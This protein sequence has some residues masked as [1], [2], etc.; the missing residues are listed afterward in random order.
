[1]LGRA[2][3]FDTDL[4]GSDVVRRGDPR[5]GV[6][7]RHPRSSPPT[8]FER[9]G[10]RRGLGHTDH[11]LGPPRRTPN[12]RSQTQARSSDPSPRPRALE[13]ALG[14]QAQ[15]FPAR[16]HG[17]W[18]RDAGLCVLPIEPPARGPSGDSPRAPG[19]SSPKKRSARR[20]RGPKIV[21]RPWGELGVG[22]SRLQPGGARRRGGSSVA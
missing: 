11:R 13:G 14:V 5:H 16:A 21:S 2:D 7:G 1:M 18:T 4:E 3:V 10:P 22:G 19:L 8:G 15:G 6:R 9:A 17:P 20:M 12:P